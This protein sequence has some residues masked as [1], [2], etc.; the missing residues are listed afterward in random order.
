[1]NKVEN[2]CKSLSI[3]QC[4]IGVKIKFDVEKILK[5]IKDECKSSGFTQILHKFYN[6]NYTGKKSCFNLLEMRF[7]TVST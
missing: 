1:M 7:Y 4:K 5:F 6:L 2:L 3:N